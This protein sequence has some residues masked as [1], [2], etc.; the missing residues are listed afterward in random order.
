MDYGYYARDS[1]VRL[2]RVYE[3]MVQILTLQLYLLDYL[4]FDMAK[5]YMFGFSYG[6]QMATEAGRRIG[7]QR[8]K[9][10]DSIYIFVL[11]NYRL[12]IDFNFTL[13]YVPVSTVALFR[14]SIQ[15][16]IKKNKTK[17]LMQN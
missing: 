3:P 15:S 12:P 11:I 2:M 7:H 4:G 9:E 10:I 17:C 8:F 6:G 1:Y 14:L 13:Q 16:K 5:G